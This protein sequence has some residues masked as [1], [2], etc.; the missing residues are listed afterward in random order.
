MLNA[1][2]AFSP[3]L[4][5][6]VSLKGLSS[7]SP[8]APMTPRATSL[9]TLISPCSPPRAYSVTKS[10]ALELGSSSWAKSWVK[11]PNLNFSFS[12]TFPSRRG[13]APLMA[14]SSVDLPAPFGPLRINF[15]PLITVRSTFFN[16]G[17]PSGSC[18]TLAPFN[19]INSSPMLFGGSGR[20]STGFLLLT[21]TASAGAS[22]FPSFLIR[23]K[24]FTR[25]CAELALVAL[26]PKRST[27]ACNLAASAK[28]RS[29]SALADLARNSL[30]SSYFDK[31]H[32]G[33]FSNVPALIS[34]T[35]STLRSNRA[36]SCETR[37]RL[38]S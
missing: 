13:R 18:P 5:S 22:N 11:D 25:L 9:E 35:E 1:T 19:E 37:M 30:S 23:S 27:Y 31:E 29:Y 7:L 36:A 26:A 12:M 20:F 15:I 24:A 8:N 17:G 34:A 14:E 21:T 38:P 6:F 33:Y 28:L 16:N 32:P 3:P 2:R 4:R 10:N